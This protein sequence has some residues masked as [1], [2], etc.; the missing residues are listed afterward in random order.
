M[1]TNAQEFLFQR[2]KEILPHNASLVETVADVLHLSSDSAY[3]RIRNETP[4]VLDEAKQ[5]C[6]HFRLSLDQL[7][8]V[9]GN[10][11][12]FQNTRINNELY[13]Y[14]KYL[15]DLLKNLKQINSFEQKEII[16]LT[17]DVPLFHNFYFQP[18]TA[19]RY[20]FWMK[21]I[22][23]HP[24]FVSRGIDLH[25][26]PPE[27]EALS[28]ELLKTYTFI[29]SIEIWNTECINAVISQIEFYKESG[30]FSSSVDMGSV[31]DALREMIYHL[32]AQV[33]WGCK[34]M[35]GENPQMKKNNF[36]FFYNRVILGETTILVRTGNEK[37]VYLNHGVLDYIV[38]RDEKFCDQCNDNLLNLM[39]RATLISR[40]SE[41]QRNIFFEVLLAKV[42]D[43]MKNL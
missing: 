13:S 16:Y 11:I 15:S 17:K 36:T 42:G 33:E 31:Y 43:R 41:K 32:K 37:T 4:L 12:L 3:R 18:L 8:E 26:I 21:T 28:K 23:Q 30:L 5:L 35:P 1:S 27:T 39:R 40:T 20:F 24:D 19:F 7:L 10:S 29:P 14:E 2:I 34:F 25:A 9:K 22:L 38:T 6:D